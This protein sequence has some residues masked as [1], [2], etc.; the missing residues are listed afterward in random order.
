MSAMRLRWA[1]LRDEPG[2]RPNRRRSVMKKLFKV[3]GLSLSLTLA[4]TQAQ[5]AGL[6]YQVFTGTEAGFLATST[7]IA[8]EK[9]AVLV[10]AQFTLSDAHRLTAMVLES[11]KTL[12]KVFVT[13]AH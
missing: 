7:L 9:E 13:H 2:A 11:G 1:S 8:G 3:L 12:T 4:A 5:A 10:D 6:T